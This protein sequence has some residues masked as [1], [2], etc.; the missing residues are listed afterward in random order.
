MLVLLDLSAA[1]DTIDHDHLLHRLESVFGITDK[2]LSWFSSYLKGRSQAI[3]IGEC[4]STLRR[5]SFGVPQGSVLGPILFCLYTAPLADIINKHKIEYHLY[6][7]DTQLYI[8]F[9]PNELCQARKRMEDCIKDV[10]LWMSSN[11]LKLNPEKTEVLFLGTPRNLRM[12]QDKSLTVGNAKISGSQCLRN[13]GSYLDEHLSMIN[14]VNLAVKSAY[15]TIKSL[16][17]IRQYL[18]PTALKKVTQSL[19]L[20][21]LDYMSILLMGSPNKITNKLQK[22]MNAAARLVTYTRR[23]DHISP[24]LKQLSWMTIKNRIRYKIAL[25]VYKGRVGKAPPYLTALIVNYTPSRPLRSGD[26]MLLQEPKIKSAIGQK[27]FSYQ[28]PKV[29]NSL[30]LHIRSQNNVAAFKRQL[31]KHFIEEL[32]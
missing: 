8:E 15:L 2:A 24:I 4:R 23:F 18:T 6:A 5:V 22:V 12:I 19:V 28:A 27:S 16:Y 25:L 11:L 30:P 20:S 17:K 32:S 7:D 29:W 10:Q 13:L 9:S 1:F 26:Q 21:R 31:K 14:Q 3:Q